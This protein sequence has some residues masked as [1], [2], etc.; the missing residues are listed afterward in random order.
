MSELKKN[1]LFIVLMDVVCVLVGKSGLLLQ[2]HFC[3][4]PMI[5]KSS[6]STPKFTCNLQLLFIP[7]G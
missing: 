1:K 5:V 6:L 2:M 3:S 7:I 4:K